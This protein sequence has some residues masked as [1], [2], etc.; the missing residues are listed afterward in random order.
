MQLSKVLISTLL[1][2]LGS[3]G[4]WYIMY[5]QF[6][7]DKWIKS[8]IPYLLA[9]GCAWVWMKAS[10]YGVEGFNGSMWSNRFLF[11]ATGVIVAA[12]LYP[13]HYGQAF[14]LKVFI[15]LLLAVA[16]ILIALV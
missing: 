14:T 2:L 12:I 6:K 5:W 11:F 9:V 8:P 15:Q 13:L 7:S 4:H 1:F 16:I 3:V 10:K